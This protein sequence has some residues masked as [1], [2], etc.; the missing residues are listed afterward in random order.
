MVRSEGVEV[1]LHRHEDHQR[2]TGLNVP[3]DLPLWPG[4]PNEAYIEAV[5]GERFEIVVRVTKEFDSDGCPY[6]LINYG[7]DG[8]FL[9]LENRNVPKPRN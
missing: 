3:L 1:F 5:S 8:D 4:K 6:V 7:I 9:E 2:Y